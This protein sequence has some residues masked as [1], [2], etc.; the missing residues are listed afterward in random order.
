MQLKTEVL[1]TLLQTLQHHNG[2]HSS[3]MKELTESVHNP[4]E[5]SERVNNRM[6][7]NF[8]KNSTVIQD[9]L[10]HPAVID[11]AQDNI[12]NLSEQ[13]RLTENTYR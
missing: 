1:Q 6:Q 7:E 9:V 8:E 12:T 5:I 11:K 4:G 3:G 13:V 2:Q 10:K